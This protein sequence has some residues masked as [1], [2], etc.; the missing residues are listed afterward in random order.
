MPEAHETDAVL[1]A[2]AQ[3][4]DTAAF[5][6][7]VERHQ[8]TLFNGISRLVRRRED[9][10]DLMQEAFIKA[11]RGIGSFQGRAKFTTW[12]YSIAM[13]VVI[14]YRRKKGALRHGNPISLHE[15]ADP[16]GRPIDARDP[17]RRPDVVA[18][19]R[20]V[21]ERIEDGIARLDDEHRTVVVLRDLQ[22]FAYETIS[23]LLECPIGT[24]KSRLHRARLALR[25]Q[26][27]DL[28]A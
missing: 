17:G 13:N 25:E 16:D 3:G 21:R 4:G 1:V 23:G 26:L 10:E 27:K 24:V 20:E 5:G 18:E 11:Y 22:G 15:G 14:S 19:H 6:Q 8:D 7:L 12:L 2:Q 28:T 9:A